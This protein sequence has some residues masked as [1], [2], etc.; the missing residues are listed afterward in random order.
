M[1]LDDLPEVV[2]GGVEALPVELSLAVLEELACGSQRRGLA[3]EERAAGEEKGS[4]QG[5]D[6]QRGA[7]TAQACV[8]DHGPPGTVSALIVGALRRS[9]QGPKCDFSGAGAASR[10]GGAI[11]ATGRFGV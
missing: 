9:S 10:T 5:E 6:A 4:D 1:A 7:T 11:A 3:A 2:P 8:D